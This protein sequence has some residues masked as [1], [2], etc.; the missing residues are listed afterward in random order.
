MRAVLLA[1]GPSTPRQVGTPF[2]QLAVVVQKTYLYGEGTRLVLLG[3]PP[4]VQ[5]LNRLC[6]L[7]S[8]QMRPLATG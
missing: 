5:E 2:W 7:E 8:F 6:L 3:R 4:G 1:E